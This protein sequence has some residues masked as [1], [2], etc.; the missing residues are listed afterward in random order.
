MQS[1]IEHSPILS[2]SAF[3]QYSCMH[4]NNVVIEDDDNDDNL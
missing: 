4:G 1:L 3:L 2:W